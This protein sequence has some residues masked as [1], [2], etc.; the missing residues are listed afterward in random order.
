MR[1]GPNVDIVANS[2]A[3]PFPA[4][5]FDAVVCAETLEHDD[6]PPCTLAEIHRVLKPGAMFICTVAGVLFPKHDFPSDYWRVT[7]EGLKLWL[8]QFKIHVCEESEKGV[9]A[10]AFR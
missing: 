1:P 9:R 7:A 4:Q 10:V 5:S 8:K 6:D 2:H 3:L